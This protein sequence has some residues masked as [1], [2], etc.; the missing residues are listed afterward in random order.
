MKTD[1]GRGRHSSTGE[2]V[3]SCFV[4]QDTGFDPEAPGDG[5]GWRALYT[6]DGDAEV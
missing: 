4:L 6:E 2:G 3:I 5:M 1:T